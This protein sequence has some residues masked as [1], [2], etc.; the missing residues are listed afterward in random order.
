MAQATE[1]NGD[2]ITIGEV[3]GICATAASGQRDLLGC[4]A[5]YPDLF[6]VRPFDAA[7]ISSIAM[8]NTVCG[9]GL[10]ATQ[11]RM[12]NRIT[13][14]IFGVDRLMDHVATSLAE[15]DEVVARCEAVVNGSS[16]PDTDSLACFLVE[17]RDEL[18]QRPAWP[19]LGPVWREELRRMLASMRRDWTWTAARKADPTAPMPGLDEYLDQAEFGFQLVFVSHWAANSGGRVDDVGPL[20]HAGRMVQR[21]VRILNDLGTVE[22]DLDWG[23]INALLLGA[24]RS[25]ILHRLAG[26]IE[27][28][29]GLIDGLRGAHP[30]LSRYLGRMIQFNVGFYGAGD[31]WGY[32]SSAVEA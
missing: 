7:F 24:P 28:C 18:A 15:I 13:M 22:R 27:Q 5:R 11:L 6:P 8:A 21:V 4:A 30:A 31:Y 12:A 3:G 20:T 14:W 25:E 23:D 26:L 16:P 2:L 9:A 10:T 29:D 1:T 17:I 19:V 32:Q